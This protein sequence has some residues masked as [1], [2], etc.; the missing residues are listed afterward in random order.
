MWSNSGD[1]SVHDE[2]SGGR[3][4]AGSQSRSPDTLSL[5]AGGHCCFVPQE[6]LRQILEAL[7]ESIQLRMVKSYPFPLCRF[8]PICHLLFIFTANTLIT[9]HLELINRAV[10]VLSLLCHKRHWLLIAY[11]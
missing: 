9:S 6:N 4:H 7:L 5:G 2:N 1:F 8:P 3:S 11:K 10:L